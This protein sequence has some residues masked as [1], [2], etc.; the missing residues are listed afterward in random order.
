MYAWPDYFRP[1][2]AQPPTMNP[3][4]A[5][6]GT[7]LSHQHPS[8]IAK[9]KLK[10]SKK[11]NLFFL[12]FL[13]S[14]LVELVTTAVSCDQLFN[15]FLHHYKTHKSH[16][17]LPRG[18]KDFPLINDESYSAAHTTRFTSLLPSLQSVSRVIRHGLS[19]SPGPFHN[20]HI[21][22][23]RAPYKRKDS[24]GCV[25]FKSRHKRKRKEKKKF[26]S[27]RNVDLS[28]PFFLSPLV[29]IFSL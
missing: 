11:K 17:L 6:A 8:P 24:E 25:T 28:T 3:T 21:S 13:Q 4:V 12:F 18:G 16:Y 22:T 27:R 20:N 15:I 26:G 1:H 19:F 29:Y 14:H 23:T 9:G 7:P 5:G 10:M 2:Q